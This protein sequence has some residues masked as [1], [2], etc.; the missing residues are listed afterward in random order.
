MSLV[1]N[2][3]VI[4]FPLLRFSSFQVESVELA[5]NV[6]DGYE[7]RGHKIGV[8]RAEFQMR[9]EYNPSLKPKKRKNDKEKIKKM[10]EK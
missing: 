4:N 1:T 8:T 7:I 2:N 3:L 9:G 5:L 6:L 10:Q